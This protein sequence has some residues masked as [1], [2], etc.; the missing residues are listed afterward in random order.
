MSLWLGCGDGVV[1]AVLS[2]VASLPVLRRR[3]RQRR[4][5]QADEAV[6][7]DEL[8]GLPTVARWRQGAGRELATILRRGGHA[9]M[10]MIDLDRF[11]QVN[12][13]RGRQAGD[14]VLRAA[15]NAIQAEADQHDLLARFDGDTFVML[16]PGAGLD[17]AMQVAARIRSRVHTLS[18]TVQA[19]NG[20]RA[21]ADGLSVSIGTA[22]SP[23][24]GHTLDDLILTA[25]VLLFAAK[26]NGRDQV[27]SARPGFRQAGC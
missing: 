11:S 19:D 13:I 9:G 21:V 22:I 5:N 10:L 2:Q 15:A 4:R 7:R 8:T 25:K 16:I 12:E 24:D 3:P 26:D 6:V 27:R 1:V 23:S 20:S 18:V 17:E 14:K